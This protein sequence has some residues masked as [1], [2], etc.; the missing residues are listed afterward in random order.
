MKVVISTDNGQVSA[1]FG[2]CPEFTVVEIVDC[3]IRERTTIINPGH[4]PGFLPTYFH[5]MGIEAIVA[6][7]MGMRAQSLFEEMGIT[8]VA[9]VTGSV[10]ETIEKLA[11]GT[12]KGGESLC[13]PGAGR[14][15]GIEKDE[16][17]HED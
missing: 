3:K 2:R 15:Y 14:G 16:C 13:R 12:L 1:H 6:G 8:A 7:G 10:D 11:A 17:D 9:G 4:H 5:E